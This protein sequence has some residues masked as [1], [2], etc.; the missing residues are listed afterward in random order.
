MSSKKPGGL[1]DPK[2]ADFN[3]TSATSKKAYTAGYNHA[4]HDVLECLKGHVD[5]ESLLD[6]IKFKK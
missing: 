4:I 1:Y 2:L 5:S 6:T 3:I